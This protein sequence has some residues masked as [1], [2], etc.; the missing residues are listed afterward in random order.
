MTLSKQPRTPAHKIWTPARMLLTLVVCA[1]FAALISSSCSSGP[2]RETSNNSNGPSAANPA[3]PPDKTVPASRPNN[4]PPSSMPLE[5]SVLNT[6][7]KALDGRP[8][9]LA[10]YQG[11]IVIVNMWAT[12]CGPC[13][14]EIPD[15]IT[16]SQEFK[17]RG[18]EV[19]GLTT[20][21][22]EMDLEKVK[23][24]VREFKIPYK[25]GWSNQS[26]A[27]GLMQGQVRNQIPQSFIISR[28]GRVLKR[29]VG[30]NPVET[31]PKLRQALEEALKS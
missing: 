11:K 12:W 25:I 3:Q 20:E 19:V 15:L 17:S 6:E 16:V 23:D 5:P 29:F 14:S 1:F 4:A 21:D 27:M 31:P 18:V 30:F 24:F 26:V 10:D 2:A 13:R 28:D 9:K 8:F 22:E 7:L